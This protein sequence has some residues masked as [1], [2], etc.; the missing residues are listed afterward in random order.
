MRQGGAADFVVEDVEIIPVMVNG[1]DGQLFWRS[2]W[3]NKWNTITWIDPDSGLQFSIDASL[4]KV[5]ILNIAESVSL[6]NS[7]E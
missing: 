7:T 1:L 6:S 4:G 5:D 2:D 3:K